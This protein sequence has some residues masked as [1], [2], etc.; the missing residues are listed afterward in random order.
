[1]ALDFHL[2]SIGTSFA[3]LL[4]GLVARSLVAL[5]LNR[6]RLRDLV[7][8]RNASKS[9]LSSLPD[10]LQPKPSSWHPVFGNILTM[11]KAVAAF[12]PNA[13]PHLF[14]NWIRQQH[15]GLP[16]VFYMDLWPIASPMLVVLDPAAAAQ[17]TI[18]PSFQKDPSLQEFVYP[19]VGNKNLVTLE[20]SEWKMW[21]GIFNPGFS[22]AHLMSLVGRMVSDT[23]LFTEIL[24]DY[25][26]KDTLFELEDAATRLT[27]DIIG[28]VVLDRP[29]RAQTSEN[30][31]VK[32]FRDQLKW[33]PVPNDINLF[34]KYNP[35][36]FVKHRINAG[37]MN[38]YL[39]KLLEQR[40]ATRRQE[41]K[42][43][44]TKRAKPIIDLALDT[45]LSE[46]QQDGA[47][48][49]PALFKRSAID[50]FKTFLF[51]GH[52]TTSSTACYIVHLLNQNPE[53]L[54]KVC[55][56]HDDVLGPDVT[57]AAQII[58]DDPYIL[59]RLP[60]TMAVL[61]EVLRMRPP[62]STV[63]IG[64][65]DQFIEYDGEQYP[66]EDIM[67]WPA[68]YAMHHRPE[69]W[70]NAEEFKPERFLV[71]EGHTLFPVKGAWR[72]FE[73]GP[74]NCIGQELAYIELKIFMVLTL[75]N[76]DI[77]AA[78]EEQDLRKGKDN[79]AH[80]LNGDRAYQIL[81][82]TA[83]PAGGFPAKVTRRVR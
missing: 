29:L 81:I 11:G 41:E 27:V 14:L 20:G 63:R 36:K 8:I 32:A 69:L 46:T 9:A 15:P 1:M 67:V 83:K 23:V 47:V 68:A 71:K 74:R 80:T 42:A 55:Q 7:S 53:A 76:F 48:T 35:W 12:P 13:H 18:Q 6:R 44:S 22:S 31:L 33:M 26:A 38:R 52:D 43:Q 50:Q 3:V 56:E 78:Y 60:Y 82:A 19:L 57:K 77:R 54:E 10:N 70:L 58:S 30:E 40:F 28:D 62:V 65:R 34:R 39:D 59:N 51:A 16:P 25:A 17:V 75:R 66:T 4:V 21:R 73:Y 64:K 2:G 45:Y 79:S 72:P 49:L 5:Y 61:K 24:T 37:I